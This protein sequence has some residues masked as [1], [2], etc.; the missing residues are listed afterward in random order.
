MAAF[1]IPRCFVCRLLNADDV[2]RRQLTSCPRCKSVHFCTKHFDAHNK[3]YNMKT[4]SMND[5]EKMGFEF[6]YDCQ[7]YLLSTEC[8]RFLEYRNREKKNDPGFSW[9]CPAKQV[10][11]YR[12]K[13]PENWTEYLIYRK[14]PEVCY[15]NW[16][17]YPGMIVLTKSLN[18]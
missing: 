9:Y 3:L 5:D 11:K 18:R 14:C 16:S 15:K 8:L 6:H 12:K 2:N 7:S 17:T 4:K 13:F 1:H 10:K